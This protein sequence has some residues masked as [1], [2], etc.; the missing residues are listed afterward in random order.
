[1]TF[2]SYLSDPFSANYAE[3]ASFLKDYVSNNAFISFIH[4]SY[5]GDLQPWWL[6][7]LSWIHIESESSKRSPPPEKK[8]QTVQNSFEVHHA[9]IHKE[10]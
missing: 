3:T 5:S 7:S 1:M 10:Q 4:V 2:E 6:C 9:I 8:I